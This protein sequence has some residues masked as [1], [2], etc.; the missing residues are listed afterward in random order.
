V[1]YGRQWSQWEEEE[2]TVDP[3]GSLILALGGVGCE[4]AALK[5]DR[6]VD[7]SKLVEIELGDIA[8]SQ[9]ATGKIEPKAAG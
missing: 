7:P 2:K 6:T 8:R 5:P 3:P 9:V 4:S 1:K